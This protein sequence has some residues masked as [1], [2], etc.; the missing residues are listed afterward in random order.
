MAS[1]AKSIATQETGTAIE[2]P[3][4]APPTRV[5]PAGTGLGELVARGLAVGLPDTAAPDADRVFETAG[6]TVPGVLLH[7]VTT[8]PIPITKGSAK[9]ATLMCTFA[10]FRHNLGKRTSGTSEAG[11]RGARAE[12]QLARAGSRHLGQGG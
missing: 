6:F 1:L 11:I 10:A 7:D 3:C 2:M 4:A 8:S 12:N 9:P 5:Y